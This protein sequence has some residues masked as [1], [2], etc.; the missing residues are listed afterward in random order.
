LS[1][2]ECLARCPPGVAPACH[3]AA[4]SVTISGSEKEVIDFVSTLEK[5]K[6]FARQVKTGGIAF[7]SACMKKVYPSFIRELRK[8]LPV[9]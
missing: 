1:W 8:V 3:N 2:D 9:Y 5:E 6:V 4:D 7:H